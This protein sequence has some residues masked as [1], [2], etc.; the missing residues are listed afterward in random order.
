MLQIARPAPVPS[1]SSRV[2][3]RR[4]SWKIVEWNWGSMPIPLSLT[5]IDGVLAAD[6]HSR[7]VSAG[8]GPLL[9]MTPISTRGVPLVLYF[10]PLVIRLASSCPSRSR[11]PQTTGRDGRDAD[12]G[13][14]AADQLAQVGLDHR[15]Q[16]LEVHR[17]ELADHLAGPRETQHPQDHRPHPA[18]G[19]HQVP[20]EF[21]PLALEAIAVVLQQEVGKRDQRAQGFLQVVRDDVGELV[22]LL[23]LADQLLVGPR[24]APILLLQL[25]LQLV[26]LAIDPAELRVHAGQLAGADPQ[27]PLGADLR[28]DV[29]DVAAEM[30]DALVG[31][32]AGPGVDLDRPEFASRGPDAEDQAER[33]APL[34]GLEERLVGEAA[35]VGVDDVQE[36]LGLQLRE[37]PAEEFLLGRGWI[38][39][40]A[41]RIGSRRL[42]MSV[43]E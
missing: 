8:S 39:S 36:R 26:Q 19:V 32:V 4:K 13:I 30:H 42:T 1:N 28:G 23:V 11:S 35:V 37:G 5:V 31:A 6:R 33:L 40:I 27:R 18:R 29:G 14:P 7:P 41:S 24:Q 22:E 43:V 2:C 21:L 3:S 38:R 12:L 9:A 20:H 34:E 16:L 25:G 15:G 10:R 17:L